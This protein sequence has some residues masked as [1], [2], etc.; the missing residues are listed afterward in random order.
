MRDYEFVRV[1]K[2][3]GEMGLGTFRGL[4]RIE[5]RRSLLGKIYAEIFSRVLGR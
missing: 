5:L 2:G 3:L 4:L 1:W